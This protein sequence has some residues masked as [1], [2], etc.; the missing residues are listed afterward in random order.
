MRSYLR[1]LAER[2]ARHRHHR[3]DAGHDLQRRHAGVATAREKP[4]FAV[5]LGPGRRRDRR[6]AARRVARRPRP[7]RLRHGRHDGQGRRSSRTARPTMTSEYEFRDGISTPSRFVKGGGYML[8]VPAIDIA[9]VGAGGGSIAGIDAG[10]LL[11]VGPRVGRRRSR[12]RPATAAA[13]TAPTVTDANVVLGFLNPRS[14]RRRHAAGRSQR[15]REHAIAGA[16]RATRSAR[17]RRRGARHP[18]RWPTS[19]WRAP[20]APS[21]SSAAAIRATSTLIAFGGSGPRPCGRRRARCS[22]SAAS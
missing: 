12:A 19:T 4:V 1:R 18:R 22:A 3:A 16:R 5:G 10:G 15:C 11:V 9:E 8:K 6:G 14:A 17:R 13:T 7:H 20:S 2:P 21:P